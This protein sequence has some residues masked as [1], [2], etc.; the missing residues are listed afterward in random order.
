[1]SLS[2]LEVVYIFGQGRDPTP[3]DITVGWF[4]YFGGYLCW[5]QSYN[6]RRSSLY[7][8]NIVYN[9]VS[10]PAALVFATHSHP[11]ETYLLRSRLLLE[12]LELV[13]E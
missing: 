5:K 13:V 8:Y 10:W 4:S 1:M 11:V 7:I 9:K 6:L 3:I 2:F 12:L